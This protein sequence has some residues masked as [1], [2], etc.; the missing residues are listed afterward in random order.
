MRGEAV[1]K[2][3]GAISRFAYGWTVGY[4]L[5]LVLLVALTAIGVA[6]A[7]YFIGTTTFGFLIV[8]GVLAVIL[9]G[10]VMLKPELGV[11]LLVGFVYLNLSD[12]LEVSFGF[13]SVNKWL[14]GFLF[15]G[16]LANRIVVNRRAINFRAT[17]WAMVLFGLTI[18]FSSIDAQD[19]A[20]AQS[21][22]LDWVKDFLLLVMF[23]QVTYNERIWKNLQWT[24]ILSGA[25]IAGLSAFQMLTGSFDFEFFGLA[26]VPVHQIVSGFDSARVTGPLD[27][28]N[29]YA[30]ILLMVLPLAAYRFLS[31][32]SALRRTVGG[33]CTALLAATVIFTYSRGGFLALV[34]VGVLILIERRLNPYLIGAVGLILVIVGSPLLPD[35]YLNRL[36]TLTELFG[37][38]ISLQTE[39]SFRGRTSELIIAA[40]MFLDHPLTGVGVGN[41]EENYLDYSVLLGLDDRFQNREAHS[42]YLELAAEQGFLG[43]ITFSAVIGLLFAGMRRAKKNLLEIN[44]KDL[45][46]WI[47]GIQYGLT[48]YLITSI[49]LHSAY[50]RYLWLII[51]FAASV[52]VMANAVVAEHQ[53]KADDE[54]M[55]NISFTVETFKVT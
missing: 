43:V 53:A 36:G 31:D 50:A 8:G 22:M 16:T 40:Q 14:V 7:S 46:P 11:Y 47:Y 28:P 19:R 55:K 49:F 10:L 52:T 24:L 54:A 5:S 3:L 51:A 26:K 21:S 15:V 44:R 29:F 4:R 34:I 33:V 42:L 27:D 37:S 20:V 9:A 13:P 25:F 1:L 38:R 23:I 18:L 30:Q 32:E 2:P 48:S 6:I 39:R 41:Y 17:E 12:V 45:L 35:M